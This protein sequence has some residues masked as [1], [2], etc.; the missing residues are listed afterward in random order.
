MTIK[1][2]NIGKG[3]LHYTGIG[4]SFNGIMS[5]LRSAVEAHI[6]VGYQDETGFH[7]GV[8]PAGKDVSFPSES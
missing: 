6:P 5:K 1:S 7:R 8:K 2:L 3:W 4:I